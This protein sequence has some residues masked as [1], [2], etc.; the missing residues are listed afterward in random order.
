MEGFDRPDGNAPA[1]LM[2]RE[3][4]HPLKMVFKFHPSH[5][6]EEIREEIVAHSTTAHPEMP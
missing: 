3:L 5:L 1:A 4:R 2:R 6:D